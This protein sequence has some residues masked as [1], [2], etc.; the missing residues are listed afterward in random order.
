MEQPATWQ[1][2]SYNLGCESSWAPTVQS[3]AMKLD[4]WGRGSHSHPLNYS[5]WRVCWFGLVRSFL[6][7]GDTSHITCHLV[8]KEP[9]RSQE[10]RV[11]GCTHC[12]HGF[13]AL[14]KMLSPL[15]CLALFRAEVHP[16][17][18]LV[19]HLW[20]DYDNDH[21]I[22]GQGEYLLSPTWK[23]DAMSKSN[24][25]DSNGQN[26]M[27]GT[28]GQRGRGQARS[29][30]DRLKTK[31]N[32][33]LSQVVCWCCSSFWGFMWRCDDRTCTYLEVL[34]QCQSIFPVSPAVT[35][36]GWDSKK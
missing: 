24:G 19:T 21:L 1:I 22:P 34:E 8:T 5:T 14:Q 28:G 31:Q 25:C 32:K 4:W 9:L 29:K 36:R 12:K 3:A 26:E 16:P 27:E 35:W 20:G 33:K 2:D 11:T 30:A 17:H 23:G 15:A 13:L 10:S 6:W 7:K 18:L